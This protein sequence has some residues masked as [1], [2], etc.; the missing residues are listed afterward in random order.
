MIL[1]IFDDNGKLHC[2]CVC[3]KATNT[4]E[5]VPIPFSYIGDA[6]WDY[7]CTPCYNSMDFFGN[8]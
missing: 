1:E 2:C 7:F 8:I 3:K 4:V 5:F 6:D